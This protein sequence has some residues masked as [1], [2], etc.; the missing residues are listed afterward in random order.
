MGAGTTPLRTTPFNPPNA[1]ASMSN[2]ISQI[3]NGNVLQRGC[4]TIAKAVT[5]GMY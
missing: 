3:A 4:K 1:A 2:I 5:A